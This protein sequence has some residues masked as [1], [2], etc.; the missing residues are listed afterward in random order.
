MYASGV[1]V[2]VMGGLLW[3]RATRAGALAAIIAGSAG[4]LIGVFGL[5]DYGGV[6]EVVVGGAC[7]LV[8]F[9]IV[10]LLTRP[11]PAE[12]VARRLTPEPATV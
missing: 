9:V 5:L 10:S 2:P 12:A 1:F 3:K 11:E 8:A 4:G 7:S 6:P